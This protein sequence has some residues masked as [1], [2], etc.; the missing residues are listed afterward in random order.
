M[1]LEKLKD[2]ELLTDDGWRDL[3]GKNLPSKTRDPETLVFGK[4]M[5]IVHNQ[6]CHV[7]SGQGRLQGK[8]LARQRSGDKIFCVFM[9][10]FCTSF[11]LCL[12]DIVSSLILVV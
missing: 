6:E 2:N 11:A 7:I 1:A 5:R 10:T 12:L 3:H 4:L 9:A 8:R